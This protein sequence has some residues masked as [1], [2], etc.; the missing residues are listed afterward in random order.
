VVRVSPLR[1]R[2][3]DDMNVRRFCRATQRNYIRDIGRFATFLR[4]PPDTATAEDL[5][6]F[7]VDQRSTPAADSPHSLP[8]AASALHRS[9]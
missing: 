2:V 9:Q 6:R 4:R 7:Q 8:Q 3:I 5:H 1:Q